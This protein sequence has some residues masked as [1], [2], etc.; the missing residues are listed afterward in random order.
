MPQG[1]WL[2]NGEYRQ[3]NP[4]SVAQIVIDLD[5]Q[6][7]F[8]SND[9]TDWAARI[10]AIPSPPIPRMT[11]DF[12]QIHDHLAWHSTKWEKYRGTE[13]IPLWIA[14]MDFAV[15]PAVQAALVAHV[16][17]GV[18][19][20][21]RE[22]RQLADALSTYLRRHYDWAVDT[23]ALVWLPGLVLGINLAVRAA[24]A[25]GDSVVTFTPVYPPFLD[26]AKWQQRGLV[27]LPLAADGM[28]YR[29]D[30]DTLDAALTA[31]PGVRLLLLCQPHNPVGKVYLRG[32]LD[33]LAEI[34]KRHDLMVCSDEV[35]CDLILDP[36][37]RHIPFALLHPELAARTI[38]LMGPGKTYN[39]A[40]LGAA[41]AVIGNPELRRKFRLGMAHL[42]PDITALGYTAL[43][44]T[45]TDA[46]PWR[47]A[48][49]TYLRGNRDL[50]AVAMAKLKLPMTK[51]DATYLAWIDARSIPDA[52]TFFE[53][54]G[55][56]LSD[57]TP[58][59][60]PGFLRLNF[61]CPRAVLEQAL[62]RMTNAVAA[63]PVA[64]TLRRPTSTNRR[65]H[66]C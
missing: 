31:T 26:A 12:E 46:E 35:H 1:Q 19:G 20:Y 23:D 21:T 60:A 40:G 28:D 34:V 58:F 66:T 24:C 53:A 52:H 29:I 37:K 63:L 45:L 36:E 14:D 41:F 39:I 44:A 9:V 8:Q 4:L 56:G 32:E 11:S 49:L 30:F 61:G 54:H 62:L 55:V 33:A 7:L 10:I 65:K 64:H 48:L 57:G 38:T 5:P 13:T 59:G 42:V 17:H 47:Q 27:A 43:L 15:P 6:R 50:V 51:V 22:P 18:F 2:Q 3:R 25:D 16:R